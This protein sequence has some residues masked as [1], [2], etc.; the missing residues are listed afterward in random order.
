MTLVEEKAREEKYPILLLIASSNT[1]SGTKDF[2]SQEC[3]LKTEIIIYNSRK[4]RLSFYNLY[5][6]VIQV[7]FKLKSLKGNGLPFL[8]FA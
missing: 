5:L 6:L 7:G 2:P 8:S 1:A 3:F 4:S